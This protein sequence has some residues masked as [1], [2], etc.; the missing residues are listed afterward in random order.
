MGLYCITTRRLAAGS[1]GTIIPGSLVDRFSALADREVSGE[2]H[3][4]PGL[5]GAADGDRS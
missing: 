4:R 5:P 1:N 2:Y 3:Q